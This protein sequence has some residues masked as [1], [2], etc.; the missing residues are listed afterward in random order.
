MGRIGSRYF[1]DAVSAMAFGVGACWFGLHNVR[2]QALGHIGSRA[3]G[4][5]LQ[6]KGGRCI[7]LSLPLYT[8]SV[9]MAMLDE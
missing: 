2:I 9:K 5:L 3:S 7:E 1:V 4:G 8:G 6:D